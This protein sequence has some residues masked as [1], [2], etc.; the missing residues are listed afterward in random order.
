MDRR[1]EEK[2]KTHQFYVKVPKANNGT[3]EEE[4]ALF[5]NTL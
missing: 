2:K 1:L 3:I 5:G 4:M